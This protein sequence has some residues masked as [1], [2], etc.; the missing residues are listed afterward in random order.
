MT[1]ARSF[2]PLAILVAMS[3]LIGAACSDSSDDGPA[4]GSI[5]VINVPTRWASAFASDIETLNGWAPVTIA[6]S[7]ESLVETRQQPLLPPE[8]AISG[9][10]SAELPVSIYTV[11]VTQS[12]R[13]GLTAGD[14]LNVQQPGGISQ[15][16]D[17]SQQRFILE[18]DEPLQVGGSYIFWL[19]TS[20]EGLYSTSPF[21][22]MRQV[23]GAFE[24]IPAWKELGALKALTGLPAQQAIAVVIV[25]GQ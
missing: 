12:I 24:A 2:W 4:S 5:P 13:G 16:S 23:D 8:A 11:R 1:R 10:R 6:G 19:Q 3:V 25:K 14:L 20:G 15:R 18:F 21:S 22:R 9:G 7:V 17:G